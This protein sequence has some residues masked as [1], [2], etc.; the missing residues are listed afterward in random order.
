MPDAYVSYPDVPNPF[1]CGC[2][3]C[4]R[5]DCVALA[6][7]VVAAFVLVMLLLLLFAAFILEVFCATMRLFGSILLRL[8]SIAH[9]RD[10]L[11]RVSL[12][13]RQSLGALTHFTTHGTSSDFVLFEQSAAKGLV[14][15]GGGNV[16]VTF[17]NRLSLA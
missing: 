7:V 13:A 16:F 8:A 15:C 1:S 6:V 17:F 2:S 9:L 10:I 5:P 12:R 3:D 4:S 14:G 11:L